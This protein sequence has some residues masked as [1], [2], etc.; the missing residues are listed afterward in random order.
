MDIEIRG[1]IIDSDTLQ[2]VAAG[3]STHYH[4]ED[5]VLIPLHGMYDKKKLNSG[6]IAMDK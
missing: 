2:E 6:K 1:A 3:S 4:L 5:G